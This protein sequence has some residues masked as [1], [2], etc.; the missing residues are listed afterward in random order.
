[1]CGLLLSVAN[2]GN[3]NNK[4]HNAGFVGMAL[5]YGLALNSSLVFAIQSQCLLTNNIISVE[6]LNQY[7]DIPSEGPEVINENR[8]PPN[9]P[10][11]GKVEIHNLQVELSTFY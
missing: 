6:R 2:A 11:V 1:M 10:S 4:T 5:T 7:M 9:W 8:P 3:Y